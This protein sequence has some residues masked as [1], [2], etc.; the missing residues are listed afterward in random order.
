MTCLRTFLTREELEW[1]GADL[2]WSRMVRIQRACVCAVR[3]AQ[4]SR[5]YKAESK[6]WSRRNSGK[7]SE[8]VEVFDHVLSILEWLR[9]WLGCTNG[10]IACIDGGGSDRSQSV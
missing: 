7:K 1:G 9:C 3:G 10:D 5:K 2:H 6:K 8:L 4:V